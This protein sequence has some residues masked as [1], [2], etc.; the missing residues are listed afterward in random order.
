[1]I[2]P[3]RPLIESAFVTAHQHPQLP[4]TCPWAC[5]QRLQGSD[6]NT[7][8]L[9][10]HGEAVPHAI[11][12]PLPQ[13]RDARIDRSD[14]LRRRAWLQTFTGRAFTP[15]DP[16][17][18]DV[19]IEDIAHS[20]ACMNR[21]TGH[22]REP[23]SVAQHSILAST[24]IRD[25]YGASTRMQLAALLH[26]A[27]EAYLVDVP[28]PIKPFLVGYEEIE[29][30]VQHAIGEKFG[31]TL[32]DFNG[33]LVKAVDFRVLAT[34]KRDLLGPEPQSWGDL[35]EPFADVIAPMEWRE[36]E[37]AFLARFKELSRG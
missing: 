19:C 17:P 8:A 35:P 9:R 27:S 31:L 23:Y 21:F 30:R 12:V 33:A 13:Y 14:D 22:T 28:K 11:K 26:D 4:I 5:G 1:M 29:A 20:L 37:A 10:M 34:E 32:E 7:H 25:V 18:E 15:L 16:R 2:I 3:N 36:A 6:F 24:Y